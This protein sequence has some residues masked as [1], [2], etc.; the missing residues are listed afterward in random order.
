[1]SRSETHSWA[2]DSIEEFVASVEVDGKRMVQLPQW[3][4]PTAAKEG[5]VLSVKHE[6]SA[7]GVRS[8]VE[9]T[10]DRDATRR[11]HERSTA[12]PK[13]TGKEKVDPGG[14]IKF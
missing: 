3:L 4:L 2:I 5:E 14:D 10:L 8:T 1:V 7:D 6:L 12:V 13:K 11:A 9:I